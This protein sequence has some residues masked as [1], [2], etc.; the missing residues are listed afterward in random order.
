MYA[1]DPLGALAPAADFFF[2]M[3]GA[4]VVC[5]YCIRA[6][7]S[8]RPVKAFNSTPFFFKCENVE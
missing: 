3:F 8:L 6:F 2:G 7:E 1:N 4:W 5:V